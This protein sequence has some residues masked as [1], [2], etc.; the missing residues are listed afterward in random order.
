MNTVS[1]GMGRAG[2]RSKSNVKS[3]AARWLSPWWLL[4]V[5]LL[6]LPNCAL[7]Q[8][9]TT[10]GAGVFAPGDAP[11]TEAIMCDFPKPLGETE[12]RCASADDIANGM[13]L[14]EAALALNGGWNRPIALDYSEDAILE[15]NGPRKIAFLEANFPD[16]AQVC[17]N[18]GTQIP[19]VYADPAAACVAKCIDVLNWVGSPP[20]GSA[21]FCEKN[22]RPS[23]NF[24]PDV[25]YGDAC[26]DGGTP[27][28]GFFDPR[29]RQEPVKW[30]DD[31]GVEFFGANGNGIRRNAATTG[32]SENDFNAGAAS[33]QTVAFGDAWVEFAAGEN[34]RSHVIGFR[35]SCA[36]P[37]NCPDTDPGIFDVGF[38]I[39]LNADNRVYVIEAKQGS[40]FLVHGPFG[41]PYTPNERFRIRLTDKHDGKAE[42]SFSR[43]A[44]GCFAEG[45]I[46]TESPFYTYGGANPS[47]PFRVDTTFREAG[48]SLDNVTVV[49]IKQ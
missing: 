8:Y 19:E 26:T 18:C 12:S 43:I 27:K 24:L 9:G 45:A 25:C 29:R 16:G 21:E 47:Y 4:P 13:K 22:A 42:V 41:D 15:C 32:P 39:S 30:I 48:G 46:C 49:R 10:P 5:V 38:A 17:L 6:A 33:A 44:A 40:M 14:T 28:P 36:D 37:A 1:S 2:V 20:G 7:D 35:E 11:V 23:T 34:D 3:L 31:S